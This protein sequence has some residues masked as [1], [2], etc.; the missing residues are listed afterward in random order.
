MAKPRWILQTCETCGSQ[1]SMRAEGVESREHSLWPE[2]GEVPEWRATS[3]VPA[4]RPG[5][6]QHA[7]SRF[8]VRTACCPQAC[9]SSLS[10]R[11]ARCGWRSWAG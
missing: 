9:E 4:D 6:A 1:Y 7:A 8:N 10:W 2:S 11:G 3:G 5:P